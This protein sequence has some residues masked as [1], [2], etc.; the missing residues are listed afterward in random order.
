MPVLFSSHQLDLVE[1]LCDD[2]VV[3]G[4]GRV[5]AAGTVEELGARGPERLRLVV[6]DGGDTGWVRGLR[7][8]RVGD[9][10]GPVAL[11]EV[12]E[13]GSRA[14]AMLTEAVARGPVTEM[15]RVDASLSE[16]FR[17]VTA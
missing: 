7:G 14:Y 4:G 16:V 10:D 13:P 15:A 17:E 8:L 1:R 9:V 12:V 11:V 3:L 2:V 6:A 5:V